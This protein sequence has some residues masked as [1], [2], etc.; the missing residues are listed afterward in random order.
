MDKKSANGSSK[1]GGESVSQRKQLPYSVETPYGFHLDL[2][3]LKYVDDIEKGNT[4]KRVH[5]QRKARG[6]PKFSTLPRNFSLPGHG[7]RPAPKD[8]WSSTSTLG[9]KP[10]G[11]VNEVQQI[12]DFRA[13]DGDTGHGQTHSSRTQGVSLVSAKPREE[14]AS[15]AR[16]LGEQPLERPNLLRTSSMPVTIP[17]RKGSESGDEK[18]E[19]GSSENVFRAVPQDRLGLHQQITAALKRVRELEDMVRTIPE[20]KSQICSLR[21]ER[22]QLILRLQAQTKPLPPPPPQRT[23]PSPAPRTH[24]G[25]ASQP[26]GP[27]A[28]VDP[29]RTDRTASE[30]ETQRESFKCPAPSKQPDRQAALVTPLEHTAERQPEPPDN[31]AVHEV[32][33]PPEIKVFVAVPEG[34]SGEGEFL[35]IEQ[36]QAK[37]VALEAKLSEASEDLE[38]TNSLLRQQMEENRMKEEMILQLSEAGLGEGEESGDRQTERRISVD[39]QTETERAGVVEQG[40]ETE[41]MIICLTRERANTVNHRLDTDRVDRQDQETEMV[42]VCPVRPRANSMDQG[43]ETERVETMD[44]V[45]ETPP[46]DRLDQVTERP[47]DTVDQV[48]ETQTVVRVDQV[49][50]TPGGTVDQVT[51][52]QTVVRVEQVTE[53]PGGTVDQVTKTQTVVSVDQVTET[54]TVVRVDQVTETPGGTIDQVTETQT[55]V[56]VDQVTETAP[57]R[58][59]RPA[60]HRA[61]IVDQ[62][63]ETQIGDSI[64][65]ATETQT[66]PVRPVRPAR[67]RARSVDR[68]T[69]TDRVGTMDQLTET[70][71][72]QR[73]DQQ[74]ETERDRGQN[75]NNPHRALEMESAAIVSAAIE[76]AVTEIVEAESEV[77]KRTV[78]D[79]LVTERASSNSMFKDSAVTEEGFVVIE[80]VD[81]EMMAAENVVTESMV[82]EN[83][84]TISMGAENVVT[85]SMA[86]DNVVTESMAADNVVTESIVTESMAAENVVTESMAADNVVTESIDTESMV[87]ENVVTISMDT[88]NVVT[89]STAAENV[90]TE[91]MAAENVVTES[92]VTESMMAENV[93][94]ESMVTKN[95]AVVEEENVE[96]IIGNEN[97]VTI[98]ESK[99]TEP[100]FTENLATKIEVLKTTV[101]ESR[102]TDSVVLIET[103][104]PENPAATPTAS[105]SQPQTGQK[106]SRAKTGSTQAPRQGS[107]P[108][109]EQAQAPRRGS[110]PAL[111]QV[112]TRLTGLINEQW[113][114]LGS[115]QEKQETPSPSAQKPADA[116]SKV[117]TG[118]PSAGKSGPSKMSSIQNQL[119]S[120]LS[121]LSAFYSP[122]Q[123]AS[124]SKQQGL[125]SIMKKNNAADKQGNK[126]GAKKNLKFVGVNGGYE[127]TSSEESSGEEKEGAEEEEVD[128]SEQESQVEA[129]GTGEDDQGTGVQAGGTES[130]GDPQ[131]PETSQ[132]VLEDQPAAAAGEMID[133]DFMEACHYIKDHMAEVSSPDKQM[134]H[135][136]TVLYQ[137]WF[138]VSSQ[139]DSMADTVT[140]YLREVGVATPTLLRYIVN[141]ADGNGNTALHYSVSHS[142]FPVVKLLLDTGLCEVNTQNRAGY[143]A[144]MLAS[145]TA[146]DG[147][148]DMEVALQLLRQGDVNA[149]AS[150]AGQTALMLAVSHGRT[151]MVRL[152]LSCQADVNIQDKDGST[153][154]MCACEHGHTEIARILLESGLCDST[155][156]DKDGQSALSV[157]VA[158]SHTE[159]VDLLKT[160]SYPTSTTQTSTVPSATII[161]TTT[162]S[163]L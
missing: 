90:V 138:R 28:A 81:T 128:S 111:G 102:V 86:A 15:G 131:E 104:A 2:D 57:E 27:G 53:T 74:T 148:E 36:L 73:A 34:D 105:S 89:D 127:T 30:T 24:A 137:E 13:S 141:L 118:K 117:A 66:A 94:T 146:A 75:S 100:V 67:P 52:T 44:Q 43:T 19:N 20:L 114:Q 112:V 136:L 1:A 32:E 9:S 64:D 17:H 159:L 68:G 8:T 22:E 120:S 60:R 115:S 4:I 95:Q 83:V 38:R 149:R 101:T 113:A 42:V 143:T 98:K 92:I 145:L 134:K 85:E 39:Q 35:S 37:L 144:V 51:E 71:A 10:R 110:N 55:V 135:V 130:H 54:Q 25:L 132:A 157:A 106:E 88:E 49:T 7:A 76:S 108:A 46:G 129:S 65:Q 122:G 11:R 26:H 69:E 45:T 70:V 91:S 97:Y 163:L 78:T 87:A 158:G 23:S 139:K 29:G 109:L 40:T 59:L 50:E 77:T 18:T 151:A 58:P 153:S 6:P 84:V 96:Q 126:G 31:V 121:A 123:K 79:I 93:V 154:L 116:Q 61:N 160:Q 47:R 14:A 82:T 5:I 12:F 33:E 56:R 41:S 142:N 107:N 124:A 72:V 147:S 99:V 162:A 63:T 119:V 103:S 152:L 140:L 21:E 156:T 62:A 3:F 80:S 161:T 133:K 150:Q 155:L 48:T 16:A 125:K